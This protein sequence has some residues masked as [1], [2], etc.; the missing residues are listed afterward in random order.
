MIINETDESIEQRSQ[1]RS[2]SNYSKEVIED[3]VEMVNETGENNSGNH[4][5]YSLL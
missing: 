5:I 3:S 2:E 1:A 4:A